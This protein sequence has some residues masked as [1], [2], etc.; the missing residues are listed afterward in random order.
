MPIVGEEVDDDEHMLVLRVDSIEGRRI[1][2]VH[3]TRK[4]RESEASAEPQADIAPAGDDP[5]TPRPALS[6]TA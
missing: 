4:L 2:K 3:V 6:D 1:R 5:D